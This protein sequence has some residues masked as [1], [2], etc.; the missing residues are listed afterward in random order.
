MVTMSMN[1]DENI[2]KA[3]LMSNP[4]AYMLLHGC[5]WEDDVKYAYASVTWKGFKDGW[6]CGKRYQDHIGREFPLVW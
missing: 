5:H 4:E 3:F 1:E 2:K 6:N